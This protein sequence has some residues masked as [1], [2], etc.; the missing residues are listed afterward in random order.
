[1]KYKTLLSVVTFLFIFSTFAIA[2]N[3]KWKV[4][5]MM[6][7]IN[8][9]SE[10]VVEYTSISSVVVNPNAVHGHFWLKNEYVGYL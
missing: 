1:M 2:D 5:Q 8:Q 6:K 4:D 9:I 10:V 7:D 3:E